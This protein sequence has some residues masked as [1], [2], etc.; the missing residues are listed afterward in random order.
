MV[1]RWPAA[2]LR[3]FGVCSF[4]TL[5]P[6]A[7]YQ[8]RWRAEQGGCQGL[9]ALGFNAGF[10]LCLLLLFLQFFAVTYKPQ[11]RQYKVK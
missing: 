2:D 1:R 8:L 4:L 3:A 9:A 11:R 7:G 10:N 5:V 6:F